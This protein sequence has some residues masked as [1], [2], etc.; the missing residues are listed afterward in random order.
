MGINICLDANETIILRH[1][2]PV[3]EFWKEVNTKTDWVNDLEELVESL[4]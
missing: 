1:G 3:K 2:I 4:I